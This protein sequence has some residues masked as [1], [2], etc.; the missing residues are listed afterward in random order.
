MAEKFTISQLYKSHT[1][2]E[3]EDIFQL[4]EDILYNLDEYALSELCEGYSW[5]VDKLFLDI[6]N[7][8]NSLINSGGG[9]QSFSFN[10]LSSL[11]DSLDLYLKDLSLAYFVSNTVTDFDIEPYHLEWFNLVQLYRY[12]AVLAARGHSK[13]FCFSYAYPLW[14]MWKY[15]GKGK[16]GKEL[17]LITAE[18]SLSGVFID[19]I[20]TQVEENPILKDKL[21]PSGG[22][23]SWAKS[24]IETK[25][26]FVLKGKGLGSALRGLH[27][28]VLCD[29]IL[30]ESNFYN[31]KIRQQT[32][33]L[34]NS[35]IMNIPLPK[36]GKVTVVGTPFHASD[37]Y[38]FLK[39]A[40]NWRVFE[41]PGIYPDGTL[42][43]PERFSLQ[44]I[45]DK[46]ATIGSISFSREILMKPVTNQ[47]SLFPMKIM[48][49]NLV[50]TVQMV[51]NRFNFPVKLTK[52][53]LGVDLAIS[54]N[55]DES[56]DADYFAC[57]IIG[58]DELKRYWILNVY[59]DKG[60]TYLEQVNIVKRLN[61]AFKPDII[62]VESNQYQKAFAD[63]LRDNGLTNVADRATTAKNKY[64]FQIGVIAL[65]PL[66]EQ[67]RIKIPYQ[68]DIYTRNLAD[69]IM[70]EFNSITFN[71]NKLQ[72]SGL[73]DDTC[74]SIWLGITGLNYV[75]S[76][77]ILNFLEMPN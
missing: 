52:I 15:K 39:K 32:I 59:R 76:E 55:T 42:L 68:Q 56:A 41:Y 54:A 27:T 20:K 61:E 34:F 7:E 4:T 58:L 11:T 43:S 28:D 60:M 1:M 9:A 40:K 38:S 49:M 67:F 3:V 5:D 50:D 17:T 47:T 19:Q 6:V 33:D 25:N 8:S 62:M 36:I 31:S 21:F 18:E 10:Y 64:D 73:H 53:A 22:K 26:G 77:L 48:K 29:D 69:I 51:G 71:D 70:A 16:K 45:L 13:S 74:M 37:L 24:Y 35:V 72:S 63:L 75:N 66:F 44:E 2:S 12:L 65:S 57:A 14:L 46:R 23:G 30:D